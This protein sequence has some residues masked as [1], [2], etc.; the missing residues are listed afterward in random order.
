MRQDSTDAPSA[1]LHGG[2]TAEK[3]RRLPARER[4]IKEITS[5][6]YRVRVLGTIVDVDE[7]NSSALLDDGTGR[8]VILFADPEQFYS[9][10][11]GKRVRVIGKAR[12]EEEVEIEVE[13]IQDM[14]KLDLGLYEQVRYMDEKLK[15]C[16]HV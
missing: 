13:I 4:S 2:S 5:E 6:D 14:T 1:S 10:K 11:E 16:N 12:R 3:L 8:A 7:T 15:R 9:A